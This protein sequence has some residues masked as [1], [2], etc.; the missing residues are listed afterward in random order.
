MR[1]SACTDGRRPHLGAFENGLQ[2]FSA[3]VACVHTFDDICNRPPRSG[4]PASPR[5]SLRMA[6]ETNTSGL[7]LA[8]IP[9]TRSMYARSRVLV[10]LLGL[11]LVAQT[12]T[13]LSVGAGVDVVTYHYDNA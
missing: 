3:D 1:S 4:R 11:V 9:H 5:A 2:D 6:R 10:S 7:T 12:R 13:L 8:R